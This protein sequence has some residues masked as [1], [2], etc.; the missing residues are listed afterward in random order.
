MAT[1]KQ[2]V[3]SITRLVSEGDESAAINLFGDVYYVQFTPG[4]NGTSLYLDAVSNAHLGEKDFISEET[5]KKF[6]ELGF[7]IEQKTMNFSIVFESA[8]QKINEIADLVLNVFD[9]LYN[10]NHNK[11]EIEENLD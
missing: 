6:L 5:E 3:K 4:K 11:L 7:E 2:I 9:N 1:R 8:K 10:F